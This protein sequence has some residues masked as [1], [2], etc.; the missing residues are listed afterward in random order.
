MEFWFYL[1]ITVGKYEVGIPGI[2]F[3]G[4]RWHAWHAMIYWRGQNMCW[5][6]QLLAA[7]VTPPA[8][9]PPIPY[10]PNYIPLCSALLAQKIQKK[11][12]KKRR[13]C[14]LHFHGNCVVAVAPNLSATND[15]W[16]G[17]QSVLNRTEYIFIFLHRLTCLSYFR[18]GVG[19]S[20][21]RNWIRIRSWRIQSHR[22][23]SVAL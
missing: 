14:S 2:S 16:R 17:N 23:S 15:P 13:V 9:T 10:F 1:L 5:K 18:P 11:K 6:W 3:C 4:C 22:S 21:A 8:L 20:S 19:I 12:V 7:S